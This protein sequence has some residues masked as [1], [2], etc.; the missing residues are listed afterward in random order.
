MATTG[1]KESFLSRQFSMVQE[2]SG[3]IIM[4]NYAQDI[5]A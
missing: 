2:A 3:T 4:V 5:A 1:D